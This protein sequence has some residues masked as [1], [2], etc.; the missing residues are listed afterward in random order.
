MIERPIFENSC[1]RDLGSMNKK[2]YDG[3][4]KKAL[5]AKARFVIITTN[6]FKRLL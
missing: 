5:L 3:K 6:N 4:T 2:K 1:V